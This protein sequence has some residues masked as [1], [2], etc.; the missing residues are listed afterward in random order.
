M[1]NIKNQI[2]VKDNFFD[3]NIYKKIILNISKLKFYNRNTLLSE[4][5]KNVY[6]KTYFDVPLDFNHFAVKEVVK[7]LREDYPLDILSHEHSYFLSTKHIGATIHNDG[8]CDVNCLIYLKGKNLMNSGTGFYDRVGDTYNLNTHVGFKEN[9]ALIFD[10]K[11][12]HASTQF[13]KN[14]G[15]RYVMANFFKNG[16]KK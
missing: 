14:C 1:F 6:N 4:E 5:H 13:E 8:H 9:R 16:D 3:N 7:K 2:I 10:S 15:S 12:C 11:I